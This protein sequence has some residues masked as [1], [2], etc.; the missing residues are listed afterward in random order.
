[1]FSGSCIKAR[2]FP[3]CGENPIVLIQNER[4]TVG[5]RVRFRY[6]VGGSNDARLR[7]NLVLTDNLTTATGTRA[8]F[9][10]ECL[11]DALATVFE[12]GLAL[13]VARKS[14]HADRV[15]CCMDV[16][17]LEGVAGFQGKNGFEYLVGRGV[18]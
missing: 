12:S 13:G 11:A 1:M 9:R 7:G 6:A 18:R 3:H 16:D 5:I 8:A 14:R 10:D 4:E 2:S 15:G 17:S